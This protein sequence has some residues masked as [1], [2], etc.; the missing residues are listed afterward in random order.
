MPKTTNR[1]FSIIIFCFFIF[2]TSTIF[3]QLTANAGP[4][5]TICPNA[6]IAIGGTPAAS[7]GQP[8]YT[9]SWSPSAGLSNSTIANPIA[10][11][12]TTT[13]YTLSLTDNTGGVTTD[14]VTV[15]LSYINNVSAGNDTS[16]CAD[17][18]VQIGGLLN[19][20]GMGVTYS[21]AP[22]STLNSS[23]A[24][25]PIATPTQTTTYTL[26]ATIAGCPPI[27]DDVTVTFITPPIVDA[28]ATVTI[29]QGQTITL[30]ASGGT[31]Y[32][33]FPQNTLSYFNTAN[34]D[35][36][37]VI[38]TL[39]TVYGSDPTEKCFSF[40]TVTVIVLPS[41]NIIIYNTFTPN[42]DQNND[43]WYIGNIEQFPDNTV[44]VYNRNGK[45]VYKKTNYDNTWDGR[46]YGNELPAGTYFYII[47][48]KNGKQAYHGTLTII[49]K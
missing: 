13:T 48:L 5:V 40:D 37:P 28:G 9:Y 36:T 47:D 10:T 34:P 12:T 6:G 24:P 29:N 38:T 18:T 32:I 11:P 8:P 21:W 22:S 27:V 45:L 43:T 39:Y 35:A 30:S 1:F 2:Y 19:V 42:K 46:A 3:A 31:A 14:I 41:D 49:R 44:E 17:S 20:N 4:D 23:T 26:T 16:V 33:W 15:S 25:Q 7:G